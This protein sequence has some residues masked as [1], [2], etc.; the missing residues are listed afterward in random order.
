MGREESPVPTSS[1]PAT[2]PE[3]LAGLAP[4]LAA[5]A[6]RLGADPAQAEDMAQEALLRMLAR[7][8]AGGAPP[9]DARRFALR[10]LGNL[11]RDRL[12]RR[13]PARTTLEALTLLPE[14]VS[15]PPE[16]RRAAQ[17]AAR[18]AVAA[19]ARL[20]EEERTL[21]LAA[22]T[23]PDGQTALAT[24]LGIPRGTLAARLARS[25]ARLRR[26]VG[27]GPHEASAALIGRLHGP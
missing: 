25:R 14:P 10:V 24:R 17:Q 6:R 22:L 8:R 18:H 20:P 12:R 7:H 5:R 21:L 13:R 16:R 11:W 19:I 15:C 9:H 27:L 23:S 4:A 3:T 26:E 1:I 2:L